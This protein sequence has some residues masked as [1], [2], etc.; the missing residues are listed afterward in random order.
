MRT[1]KFCLSV[2]PQVFKSSTSRIVEACLKLIDAP[3]SELR[4]VVLVCCIDG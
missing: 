3:N 2:V 4:E 1:L